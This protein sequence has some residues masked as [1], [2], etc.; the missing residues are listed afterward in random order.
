MV[1][2]NSG[3][4]NQQ[5]RHSKS[6]AE[7]RTA[8]EDAAAVAE[9]EH[10]PALKRQQDEELQRLADE[11][12]RI[13][14]LKRQQDEEEYNGSKSVDDGVEQR[15]VYGNWKRGWKGEKEGGIVKGKRSMTA[16]ARCSMAADKPL[17]KSGDTNSKSSSNTSGISVPVPGTLGIL[18]TS[19]TNRS[20]R[21]M[22][23]A[24]SNNVSGNPVPVSGTLGI[25]G[26]SRTNRGLRGMNSANSSNSKTRTGNDTRGVSSKSKRIA[27]N[28]TVSTRGHNW[29]G[30]SRGGQGSRMPLPGGIGTQV[31]IENKPRSA[32]G[33]N[34]QI[35]DSYSTES[36]NNMGS[37]D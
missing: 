30:F 5:Q 14:E 3:A 35:L 10:I 15:A 17:D 31:S 36:S 7:R 6:Q 8:E 23:S 29:E 27:N 11:D 25:L 1:H 9:A 33:K 4:L 2:V 21:G 32:K 12:A 26:M 20:L 28:Y 16:S 37:T 22:N 18:G 24:K 19:R 13:A 34:K